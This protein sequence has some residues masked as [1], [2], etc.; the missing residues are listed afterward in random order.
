[1]VV[2]ILSSSH[3][4][5]R[6]TNLG[7]ELSRNQQNPPTTSPFGSDLLA[8]IKVSPEAVWGSVGTKFMHPEKHFYVV[9]LNRLII[10]NI[11]NTRIHIQQI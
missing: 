2:S 3:V 8:W 5:L 9:A 4:G 1:M 7:L 11:I 6:G 10:V